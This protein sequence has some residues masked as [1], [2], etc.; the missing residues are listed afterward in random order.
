MEHEEWVVRAM[1]T[2]ICVYDTTLERITVPME[3]NEVEN[4]L[5]LIPYA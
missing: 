5:T 1:E 4:E 3:V 2:D